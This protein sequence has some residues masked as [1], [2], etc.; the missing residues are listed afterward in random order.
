MPFFKFA[1]MAQWKSDEKINAT[2]KI[3]GSLLNPGNLLKKKKYVL[4]REI[5]N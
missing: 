2:R 5:R 3:P 1:K 4:K